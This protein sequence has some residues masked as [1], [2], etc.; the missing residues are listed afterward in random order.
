MMIDVDQAIAKDKTL[1]FEHVERL[2]GSTFK[3]CSTIVVV[4][5]RGKIHHRVVS[6]WESMITPMNHRR[7]KVYA[8]GDEVGIAY[9]RM[10][11]EILKN[12]MFAGYKYVLTLEDDNLPPPDAHVRLLESIDVGPFAAVS[13]IY[14]T[15]GGYNM[16]QAYGNPREFER[17]G[18][19]TF[20]PR[21]VMLAMRGGNLIEVNGIGMGCA[22]WRIEIF[23]KFPPPWFV[24]VNDVFPERKAIEMKTQ[25]LYFCERMRRAGMRLAVDLRVRVG[26]LDVE[27]GVVY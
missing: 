12:E 11:E 17:T 27:T 14:F 15:K 20:E 9:N 21:D 25:D 5:T 2:H 6:S 10:I 7:A 19:C 13:G 8:V 23:R 4:P 24:T 16:P 18:V 22:L 3:D 1:G 26:H